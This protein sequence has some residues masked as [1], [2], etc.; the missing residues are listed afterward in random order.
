MWLVKKWDE[1]FVVNN[2]RQNNDIKKWKKIA[3]DFR[4]L[5]FG[6]SCDIIISSFFRLKK[7]K[8]KK[9]DMF[10]LSLIYGLRTKIC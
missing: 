1:K 8:E 5:L 6:V 3:K 9:T 4:L 7:K 2:T 10:S